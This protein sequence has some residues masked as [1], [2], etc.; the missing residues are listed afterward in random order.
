MNNSPTHI[1]E[2]I[3]RDI[4]SVVSDI[5]NEAEPLK[6]IFSKTSF[7]SV[8][9]GASNLTL[10]FP[11][12][13]TERTPV[14]PARMISKGVE[15]KAVTMLQ[16]LFSAIS[17]SDCKNALD[18]VARIHTNIDM[19]DDMNIDDFVGA[20]DKLA[21]QEG[22]GVEIIDQKLYDAV[23]ED[24]KNINYFL[25][26]N[27]VPKALNYYKVD[28]SRA[29]GLIIETDLDYEEDER[30]FKTATDAI[31]RQ[32]LDTDIKK[33]N[34]L[35]PSMMIIKF[36][37]TS[38]VK[39]VPTTA[40]I[41]VKAKL[42]YVSSE[43]MLNRIVLKNKDKNGLFNFLKAA[44]RE[45]SFWKDFVFAVDRA[46]LDAISTSGRGSSN[47][48]WKLLERRAI[49][50]RIKRTMGMAN[51]ASA[52]TTLIISK[53]E[54]EILKKEYQ[55]DVKRPGV[56]VP[57]ME[58]YNLMGFV[59]CDQVLEKVDFIFDDASNEYETISFTHLE[60]EDNGNYKK[61]INLLAKSR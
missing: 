17:F 19:S 59:I 11:C 39:A 1:H 60:R 29:D 36:Y 16:M 52:I 61:V 34:E 28:S 50:S 5:S 38:D 3:I 8:A 37:S 33:A 14:E 58:A 4:V 56:I 23:M 44:T 27:Y 24:M 7:S 40:V 22:S 6:G 30:R 55:I 32:I 12:I 53:E 54:A 2:T 57:I 41:G 47:K 21:T 31:S 26:E 51:D 42:Q 48:V 43:D 10:V 13:A 25:D 46:K 49:K 18:H 9:K 15:R 20:M 35:I 45:I